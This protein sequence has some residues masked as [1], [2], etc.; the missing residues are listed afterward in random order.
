MAMRQE[1]MVRQFIEA[2]RIDPDKVVGNR[3]SQ[4][5]IDQME[6]GVNLVRIP[7]MAWDIELDIFNGHITYT[8]IG[9][10]YLTKQGVLSFKHITQRTRLWQPIEE[11]PV[12]A[13]VYLVNGD[14]P[15][16]NFGQEDYDEDLYVLGNGHELTPLTVGEHVAVPFYYARGEGVIAGEELMCPEEALIKAGYGIEGLEDLVN[17]CKFT[18]W[19]VAYKLTTGKESKYK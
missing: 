1:E 18:L 17:G 13:R 4:S 8:R 16:E 3:V 10:A 19:S 9:M 7:M 12:G 11:V 5:H 15:F 14:G 2:G 6:G